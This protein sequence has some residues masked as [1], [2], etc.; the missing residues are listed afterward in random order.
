MSVP[1]RAEPHVW[2]STGVNVVERSLGLVE[3]D[4]HSL[5]SSSSFIIGFFDFLPIK[6]LLVHVGVRSRNEWGECFPMAPAGEVN[7]DAVR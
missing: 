5:R 4:K 7:F 3:Q 1:C 6:D 2:S